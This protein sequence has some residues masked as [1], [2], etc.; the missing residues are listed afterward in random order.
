LLEKTGGKSGDYH[1]AA[2]NAK[3]SSGRRKP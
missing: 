1:R 3:K 2:K